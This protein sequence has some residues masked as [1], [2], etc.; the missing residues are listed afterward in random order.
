MGPKSTT[1]SPERSPLGGSSAVLSPTSYLLQVRSAA[2]F[3][4]GS[5][6]AQVHSLSESRGPVLPTER[7]ARLGRLHRPGPTAEAQ[8]RPLQQETTQRAAAAASNHR[9]AEGRR[10]APDPPAG[11]GGGGEKRRRPPRGRGRGGTVS[12]PRSRSATRVVPV[13]TA[14]SARSGRPR[15]PAPAAHGMEQARGGDCGRRTREGWREC[16]GG[17]RGGGGGGGRGGCWWQWGRGK[18][19]GKKRRWER[20]LGLA[21]LE[22]RV[23]AAPEPAR[24]GPRGSRGRCEEA[25]LSERV[26]AGGRARR[27]KA[28][29]GGSRERRA[30]LHSGA[31]GRACALRRRSR[32]RG[33]RGGG[34]ESEEGGVGGG[35]VRGALRSLPPEELP[36]PLCRRHSAAILGS[37][38]GGGDDPRL[39]CGTHR[40]SASPAQP[41]AFLFSSLT[42]PPV[43]SPAGRLL[44][45]EGD[46]LW[47]KGSGGAWWRPSPLPHFPALSSLGLG[48]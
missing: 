10:A 22:V 33:G 12:S 29:V 43:R 19:G 26:R 38:C 25:P 13:P 36:P 32:G 14:R 18:G 7:A 9:P 42:F 41:H 5:T 15:L 8:A 46:P 17:G 23:R 16:G 34:G 37:L 47:T 35:G 4:R 20:R 6:P 31:C 24:Q 11:A 45:S 44:T 39:G 21:P 1:R 28:V 40:P 3:P 48:L 27:P 2:P 30:Q